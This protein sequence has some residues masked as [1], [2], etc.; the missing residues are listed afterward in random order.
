LSIFKR[1]FDENNATKTAEG[2]YWDRYPPNAHFSPFFT[3]FWYIL[4][5][6]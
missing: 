5:I 2:N 3:G 6:A 4:S 1:E